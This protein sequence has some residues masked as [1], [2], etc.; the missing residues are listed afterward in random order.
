MSFDIIG[1][2]HGHAQTL[3]RLLVRLGYAQVQGVYRHPKRRAIF[4]GDFIDGGPHQ[5]ATLEIVRPMV[6]T[7]HA[8]AV[9]GNHEFNALAYA[10]PRQDGSHLR[11]RDPDNRRQH[12]AFL[13]E[14]PADGPDYL[15]VMDWFRTLPLWLDLDELRVVHACWDREVIARIARCLDGARLTETLLRRASTRG[16]QEYVDVETLL[17]GREIPLPE[18]YHYFDRYGKRRHHIRIRWWDRAG[19]T[20]RDRYLGSPE[21]LT[22]IPEDEV[23]GDHG[24]EYDHTEPPV[25]IGHYWLTGDPVPLAGNVTC[26]DYSVGKPGGKLV[27]YR[28]DS[29]RRLRK[30]GFVWVERVE[31]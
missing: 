7:G 25:F 15:D 2:I 6:E 4:L 9:M 10:T 12:A 27:A 26:L 1:D 22:Q 16:R 21:W 24:I 30:G 28:W 8:L 18:G 29:E 17:K 11:P 3:E 5:R 19:T 23:A 14:Y 20:Y 13:A 31:P